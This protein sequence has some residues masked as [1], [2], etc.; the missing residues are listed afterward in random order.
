ML[1]EKKRLII[2]AMRDRESHSFTPKLMSIIVPRDVMAHQ[3][4]DYTRKGDLFHYI[5][6]H[7]SSFMGNTNNDNHFVL[8]FPTTLG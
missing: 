7:K 8:I 5:Q 2:L 3:I 6:K 4:F 1:K